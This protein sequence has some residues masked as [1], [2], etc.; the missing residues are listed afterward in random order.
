MVFTSVPDALKKTTGPDDG[1]P[2]GW[3]RL[4]RCDQ[5]QMPRC[6]PCEGVGGHA[7]GDKNDE[8]DPVACEVVSL[9]S[10]QVGCNAVTRAGLVHGFTLMVDPPRLCRCTV[11]TL[12]FEDNT[13]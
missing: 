11:D 2:K 3:D 6:Q 8:Y 5:D 9:Y 12:P 10:R 7:Y 4:R 1:N 13:Q